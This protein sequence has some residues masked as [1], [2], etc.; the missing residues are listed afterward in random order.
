MVRD[1]AVQLYSVREFSK[2]D[3]AATLKTVADIGFKAVEPAGFF[4]MSPEEFLK[5]INDLGLKLYSSHSPWANANNLEECID[6]AGR[7]G[8]DRIVCGYGPE[9]Y[10]DLDAIKRT[11]E[12]T[13]IMQ[14]KLEKAGFMLFQHNHNWEFERIDGKLKYEIYAELCPKVKFQLDAFWSTN[15]GVED[16]VDMMKLFSDRVVAL[17]MKDGVLN[18]SAEELK[19]TDGTYDRVVDLLPLGEGDLPIPAIV[20][21]TPERVNNIIVELDYCRVEMIEALKRSYK[22]MV[23]NGLALGNK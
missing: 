2:K 10:K 20:A 12:T 22:Y 23:S 5:R 17:H 18:Q 15:F 16:P 7:L 21:A 14:E 8:L 3:F 1:L 9:D 4:D 6:I 11:A 13:S 19:I